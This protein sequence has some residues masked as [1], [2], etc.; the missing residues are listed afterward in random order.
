MY[1][2]CSCHCPRSC[3]GLKPAHRSSYGGCGLWVLC[4]A[5]EPLLLCALPAVVC[6]VYTTTDGRSAP[7][8]VPAVMMAGA[9]VLLGVAL[10]A[11]D[12][13][14]RTWPAAADAIQPFDMSVQELGPLGLVLLGIGLC[15]LLVRPTQAGLLFSFSLLGIVAWLF[16]AAAVRS[17]QL[18]I[19]LVFACPTIGSGMSWL[20]RGRSNRVHTS[21][22]LIVCFLFPMINFAAHAAAVRELRDEHA[23]WWARARALADVLPEDAV[24]ATVVGADEPITRLWQFAATDGRPIVS[25]PL[26]ARRVVQLGTTRRVFVFE[27]TRQLLE[28][29]G[30]RFAELGPA[31]A[32]ISLASYLGQLPRGTF[33]AAAVGS[34]IA[35]TLRPQLLTAFRAIGGG[36]APD[37]VGPFYGIIGI[38]GSAAVVEE[39]SGSAVQIHVAAGDVVDKRGTLFPATLDL[40][41][42]PGGARISINGAPMLEDVT[43]MAVVLLGPGPLARESFTVFARDDEL[44]V[45]LDMSGRATARLVEWNRCAQVQADEWVDVSRVVASG[46]FGISFSDRPDDGSLALYLTAARRLLTVESDTSWALRPTIDFEVFD[47]AD[48]ADTAA[49]DHLFALDGLES[50]PELRRQRFVHLAHVDVGSAEPPLADLRLDGNPAFAIA[51]R[52]GPVEAPA[53][54]I[55]CIGG[56]GGCTRAAR[57]GRADDTPSMTVSEAARPF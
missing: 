13:G 24:V 42:A 9:V 12:L 17:E 45:P 23:G 14:L 10:G 1:R 54:A 38:V 52:L 49:L 57:L 44:R 2:Y 15:G 47:R 41:S 29:L 25:M 31:R 16:G 7:G 46:N 48:P 40:E 51:R 5:A 6:F 33:V 35:Q 20:A 11:R 28:L 8:P 39:A 19:A 37:N 26:I 32:D 18:L 30:F 55:C 21:A 36:R 22:A 27:P 3:G 56:I 53:V 34:N 43:D 50:L 4:T